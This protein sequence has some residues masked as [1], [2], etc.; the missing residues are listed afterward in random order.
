[1]ACAYCVRF[2]RRGL[3]WIPRFASGCGANSSIQRIF[4]S[5]VGRGMR[6]RYVCLSRRWDNESSAVLPKIHLRDVQPVVVREP[7]FSDVY[8]RC[9]G[10]FLTSPSGSPNST[11]VFLP[12]V[13]PTRIP[14]PRWWG[15]VCAVSS[16]WRGGRRDSSGSHGQDDIADRQ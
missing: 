1:M 8:I 14:T 13:V 3:L 11:V 6:Y 5:L 2:D 7:A 15:K 10:V 4:A 9:C 12:L 16:Y